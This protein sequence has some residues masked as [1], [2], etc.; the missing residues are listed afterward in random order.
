MNMALSPKAARLRTE[1]QLSGQLI[2][3]ENCG[4]T[5]TSST[6]SW[7]CLEMVLKWCEVADISRCVKQQ[8][9]YFCSWSVH[10]Y[11]LWNFEICCVTWKSV[12]SQNV[13]VCCL[14]NFIFKYIE[15]FNMG[16]VFAPYMH[17]YSQNVLKWWLLP[18]FSR[19]YETLL[20][21]LKLDPFRSVG[22]LGFNSPEWIISNMAAIF[23]GFVAV[24]YFTL[25]SR[26]SARSL[27]YTWNRWLNYLL[28]LIAYT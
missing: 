18:I 28:S 6:S 20:L 25:T 27:F 21:Q 9:G 19:C 5:K 2:R 10:H 15:W 4:C 1:S 7:K 11:K 24:M 22:I 12:Y 26:V 8:I 14:A 17:I 23:A 16:L 3:T 13:W